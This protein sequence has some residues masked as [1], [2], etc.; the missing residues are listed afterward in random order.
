MSDQHQPQPKT[1]NELVEKYNELYD[2]Y[3]AAAEQR[4]WHFDRADKA[5]KELAE[6]KAQGGKWKAEL[7]ELK[8]LFHTQSNELFLISQ[9]ARRLLKAIDGKP[10]KQ[11]TVESTAAK[12]REKVGQTYD[13]ARVQGMERADR[14]CLWRLDAG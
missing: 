3:M 10:V 11:D 12:L 9:W 8:T 5:E 1:Y 7:E 13:A 4:A 6:A 14:Q 2:L